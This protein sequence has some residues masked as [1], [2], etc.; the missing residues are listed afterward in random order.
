MNDLYIV[1]LFHLRDRGN[2]YPSF[3]QMARLIGD[4]EATLGR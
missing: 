1:V 3:A 2:F 4:S